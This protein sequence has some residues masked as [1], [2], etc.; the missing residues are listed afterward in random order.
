[1][2]SHMD[3]WPTTATMTGLKAPPNGEIMDNNGKP[4]WFDGIDNTA[5]VTGKAMHSARASWIYIDGENFQGMRV[6]VDGDPEAPWLRIAWKIHSSKDTWLG[7]EL[8]LGALGR[9]TT[10]PW[11]RSRNMT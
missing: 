9:L 3:V 7:P 10:S 4:I 1:M 5:D 2:M 11:T 8:N 6:D